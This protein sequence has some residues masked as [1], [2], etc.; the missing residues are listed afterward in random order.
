VDANRVVFTLDPQRRL[1]SGLAAPV[2]EIE[3]VRVQSGEHGFLARFDKE[4]GAFF[5]VLDEF[6][7]F[8]QELEFPADS[9][10]A[11]EKGVADIDMEIIDREAL[12]VLL[13]L[14]GDLFALH[15]IGYIRPV[16]SARTEQEE[17]HLDVV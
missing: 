12:P 11:G 5:R 13:L 8:E 15:E 4:V 6:F 14:A 10:E 3:D 7:I 16:F 17:M 9:T 2:V 1:F